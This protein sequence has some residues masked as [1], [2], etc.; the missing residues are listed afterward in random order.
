[1]QG[2]CTGLTFVAGES[3]LDAHKLGDL[4]ILCLNGCDSEKV[5]E[6]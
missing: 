6:G 2:L 4:P 3:Y 5:P 1:M